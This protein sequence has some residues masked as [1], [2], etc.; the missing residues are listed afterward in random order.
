MALLSPGSADAGVAR[1]YTLHPGDLACA[2]RGDRLE[3][4]LGSCVT[5]ILA[6]PR[7][8]VAAMC[9]VVHAGLPGSV[10]QPDNCAYGEVALAA[11]A[12]QLRLRGLAPQ[13][14][15]ALVIG[16]GN[17]F[18]QQFTQGHV[19]E[20]NARWALAALQ[21]EG[22][23]VVHQDLGGSAYRRLGWTVGPGAPDVVAV[24]V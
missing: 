6:D 3:T 5:I 8:S 11:M 19:G 2:E 17:M 21:R 4:L 7:R 13:L 24:P 9:H 22:I 12:A 16:G 20:H 10:G 14:C 23:A 1:H 18:P 15:E